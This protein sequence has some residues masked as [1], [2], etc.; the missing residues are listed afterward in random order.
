M[1]NDQ[2]IF[3]YFCETSNFFELKRI[4]V[5]FCQK[6]PLWSLL[7]HSTQYHIQVFFSQVWFESRPKRSQ[8]KIPSN[9]TFTFG[10]YLDAFYI[11]K[12]TITANTLK[13]G[14]LTSAF[15]SQVPWW[16]VGRY[17]FDLLFLSS[18]WQPLARFCEF[19][20]NTSFSIKLV[21]ATTS[22]ATSLLKP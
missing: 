14:Q 1:E 3:I 21:K 5:F 4:W 22:K 20:S 9:K 15:D 2:F 7:P 12:N 6:W 10:P 11:A 8:F 16:C 13:I 17:K 19:C 18:N